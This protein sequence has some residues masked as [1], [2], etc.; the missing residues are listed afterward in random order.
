M[1]MKP[2][3][4]SF[5]LISFFAL[6]L[7]RHQ[8][9]RP[10]FSEGDLIQITTKV[11]DEP[12]R[13]QT[14][15][16]LRLKGLKVYLPLYPE[17]HYGDKVVVQG[18]VEGDKLASPQLVQIL[19]SSN[20]IFLTRQKILDFFTDCLP[21]PHAALVAGVVL[22]SKSGLP[23][24]FYTKLKDT[25]TIHVVVAS[26][27]NVTLVAGFLL[28]SALTITSRKKAVILS[29]VGIWLYSILSGFDAP[30]IRASIMGTIAF[31]AQGLGKLYNAVRALI[32]SALL[33]L[34]VNPGWLTD[35]GF[36]LSF[37]ATASLMLFESRVAN[38][39]RFVPKIIRENLSTTIAAQIGVAPILFVTF[40]QFNILS[41]LINALILWTIPPMTII[42]MLVGTLALVLPQIAK[43]IILLVYPLTTWFVKVVELF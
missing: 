25:G 6:T 16:Y 34:L 31:S 10:S 39:L 29:L 17:I 24:S 2:I 5:L 9:A 23:D 14:A 15:Q 19:H 27:M 7:V 40:G 38:L 41:P 18:Q 12:I 3:L 21:Q 11:A 1:S 37:V 22:G 32:I 43:F 8:L 26:G 33:M 36:I 35:L 13:Y 30:I 28:S 4:T 42:G 20:P